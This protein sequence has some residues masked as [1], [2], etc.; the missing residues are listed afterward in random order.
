MGL[1]NVDFHRGWS[2]K[3]TEKRF[4]LLKFFLESIFL[5]T[6]SINEV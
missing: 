4:E 6:V 2:Y 3:S 1:K 5:E